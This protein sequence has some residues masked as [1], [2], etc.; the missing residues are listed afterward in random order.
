MW[1]HMGKIEG[2]GR[3]MWFYTTSLLVNEKKRDT[4]QTKSIEPAQFRQSGEAGG[5]R[6]LSGLVTTL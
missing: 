2:S 1:R 4:I 3:G 5:E 6:R